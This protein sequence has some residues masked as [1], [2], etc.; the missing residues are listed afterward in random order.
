MAKFSYFL[1][2]ARTTRS[3]LKQALSYRGHTSRLYSNPT[4]QLSYCK[5]VPFLERQATRT[6][7]GSTLELQVGWLGCRRAGGA[8]G[9]G[10]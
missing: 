7:Q 8:E 9:K 6:A 5:Q 1:E 4:L 2:C 3:I 10:G